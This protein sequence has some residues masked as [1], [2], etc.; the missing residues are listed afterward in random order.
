[1]LE[2]LQQFSVYP[3]IFRGTTI[4]YV[5]PT[6]FPDG[7]VGEDVTEKSWWVQETWSFL[8]MSIVVLG[9]WICKVL[10]L[11]NHEHSSFIRKISSSRLD[12]WTFFP[13]YT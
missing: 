9:Y 13:D 11:N 2:V 7:R 4:I 10:I 12:L 5:S 3:F 6:E 8:W 1:M